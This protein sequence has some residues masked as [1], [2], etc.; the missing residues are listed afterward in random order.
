[1]PT[2]SH[3]N[4]AR[5]F[6]LALFAFLAC[7]IEPISAACAEARGSTE[8]ASRNDKQIVGIS[9]IPDFYQG[10]FSSRVDRIISINRASF[11]KQW[12]PR[13]VVA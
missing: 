6:G 7:A 8:D 2:F 12:L 11:K 5:Y 10:L 4:R 13:N 1:M 9:F 3:R